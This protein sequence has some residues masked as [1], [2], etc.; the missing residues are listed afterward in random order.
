MNISTRLTTTDPNGH[1]AVNIYEQTLQGLMPT[2]EA[3][4][5]P[6]ALKTT[7][8]FRPALPD[9]GDD[10][11]ELVYT[12]SGVGLP[13][14]KSWQIRIIYS[15]YLHMIHVYSLDLQNPLE[16]GSTDEQ[17]E[18]ADPAVIDQITRY[19]KRAHRAYIRMVVKA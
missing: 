2:I 17:L 10:R 14:P 1:A 6:P 9:T 13:V 15:S 3:I 19:I 16:E 12:M 8:G 4:P 11:S 7:L 18:F 5:V